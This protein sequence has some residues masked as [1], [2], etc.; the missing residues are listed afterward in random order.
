MHAVRLEERFDRGFRNDP[1]PHNMKLR[2]LGWATK[3]NTQHLIV[4]FA[5]AEVF[6]RQGFLMAIIEPSE[7]LTFC[8]KQDSLR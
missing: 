7:W 2:R 4:Q 5:T 1:Q 6:L 3:P 8:H